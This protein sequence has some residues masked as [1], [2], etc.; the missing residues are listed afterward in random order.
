MTKSWWIYQRHRQT[1]PCTLSWAASG[2]CQQDGHHQASDERTE[3]KQDTL[4]F[5]SS[6]S[7]VFHSSN[8]ELTMYIST[9][10]HAYI[11]THIHMYTP[12]CMHITH[13]HTRT[14]HIHTYIHTCVHIHTY[15]N[16]H[17]YT[18]PYTRVHVHIYKHVCISN[19]HT[20]AHIY[21]STYTH[22]CIYLHIHT[23]IQTRHTHTRTQCGTLPYS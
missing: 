8:K 22:M 1:A 14:H 7:Q 11:S 15:T 21:I 13:A 17:M 4:A 9:Y 10:T 6:L 18:Y 20:C 16:P 5:L 12:T 19:I 23:H 3:H 2:L